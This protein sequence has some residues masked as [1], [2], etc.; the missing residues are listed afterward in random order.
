MCGRFSLSASPEAIQELFSL[1]DAPKSPARYNIAP[2][3]PV[4][5][6]RATTLGGKRDFTFFN[7]GLVPFWAKE[8]SIGARM[9]NARAETVAEKPSFRA[10]FRYR[11]CLIPADGYF[12]WVNTDEGKQPF[13]IHQ[14][15]NA[16]F[17]FAGLWERWESPDGSAIESC[18]IITTEAN[19]DVR[20]IHHRMP[21]I[22]FPQDFER[23]LSPEDQKGTALL[24]VIQQIPEGVLVA[25]PVSKAVN[26][27]VNDSPE[28]IQPLAAPA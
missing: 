4:A 21:A 10:A 9:I 1:S 12:E 13:H 23:W 25:N 28:C 15:S 8:P 16:P 11:R 18:T 2:S 26:R 14:P 5:A 17:A 27:P 6:V 24:P 19:Q 3:Q 20:K 22:L 7:W